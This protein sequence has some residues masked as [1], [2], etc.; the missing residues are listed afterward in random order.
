MTVVG[1]TLR[2]G[3]W[4]VNPA[5]SMSGARAASDEDERRLRE[6]GRASV[7]LRMLMLARRAAGG[8][9]VNRQ[10]QQRRHPQ[11]RQGTVQDGHT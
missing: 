6:T 7:R 10:P 2:T 8:R 3:N 9:H 5:C 1:E 4:G 11:V